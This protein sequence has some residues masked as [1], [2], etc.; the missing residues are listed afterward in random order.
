[1]DNFLKVVMFENNFDSFESYARD[2]KRF[3][4]CWLLLFVLFIFGVVFFDVGILMFCFLLGLIVWVFYRD[5]NDN[6]ESF[7]PKDWKEKSVVD[8]EENCPVILDKELNTIVYFEKTYLCSGVRLSDAEFLNEGFVISNL[9]LENN[10]YFDLSGQKKNCVVLQEFLFEDERFS[11][12]FSKKRMA[13]ERKSGCSE[14]KCRYIFY[15]NQFVC[16]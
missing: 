8:L 11:K 13:R 12:V 9:S 6:Y 15:T 1:M 14:I 7:A 4:V 10:V 16:S 2:I 5:L 3:F